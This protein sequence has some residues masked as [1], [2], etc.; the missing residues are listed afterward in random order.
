MYRRRIEPYLYIYSKD[1]NINTAIENV[2]VSMAF[3]D[4]MFKILEDLEVFLIIYR[5]LVRLDIFKLEEI[6]RGLST[7]KQ[8]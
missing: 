7:S 3:I 6:A 8:Q 5:D 4:N 1:V 2:G